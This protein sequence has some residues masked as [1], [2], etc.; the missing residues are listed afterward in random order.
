M[1]EPA[2][3]GD[4]FQK[5]LEELGLTVHWTQVT[6]QFREY[7][8]RGMSKEDALLAALDD[9]T[10]RSADLEELRLE[11]AREHHRLMEHSFEVEITVPDET[12][13]V[14]ERQMALVGEEPDENPDQYLDFV[15]EHLHVDVSQNNA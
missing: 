1:S 8:D 13:S 10:N 9:Y 3:G 14:I 11:F 4:E 5:N 2:V 15:L 12:Q 6:E 7:H